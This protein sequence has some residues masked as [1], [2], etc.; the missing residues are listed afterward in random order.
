[1]SLE[2]APPTE[3][4]FIP[5]GALPDI[6]LHGEYSRGEEIKLAAEILAK[7]FNLPRGGDLAVRLHHILTIT[8]GAMDDAFEA[9]KSLWG[10]PPV[11]ERYKKGDPVL[12][13]RCGAKG[14]PNGSSQSRRRIYVCPNHHGTGEKKKRFSERTSAEYTTL[15][16]AYTALTLMRTSEG[17]SMNTI[18]RSLGVPGAI[19]ESAIHLLDRGELKEI[20]LENLKNADWSSPTFMDAVF[21]CGWATILLRMEKKPTSGSPRP[22]TTYRR[23]AS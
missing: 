8:L 19:V 11:G 16:F 7:K 17:A 23:E 14:T 4:G 1:M 13:C 9:L 22:R 15:M 18:Q 10:I 6:T 21:A 12:T 3:Y 2:T 20:A 5:V